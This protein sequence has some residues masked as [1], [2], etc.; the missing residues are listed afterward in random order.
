M[1]CKTADAADHA[2]RGRLEADHLGQEGGDGDRL[3]HLGGWRVAAATGLVGVDDA[4]AGAGV[5]DGRP[6]RAAD[7][8]APLLLDESTVKTTGFPDPP[9]VACRT[10]LAPTVPLLGAWKLITCVKR[11]VTGIVCCTCAAAA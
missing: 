5:V 3:L 9:P 11:A 1:A 6:V 8:H 7:R 10:A 4:V 2:A